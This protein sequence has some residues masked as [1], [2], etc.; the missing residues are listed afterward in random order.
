MS[1]EVEGGPKPPLEQDGF[2]LMKKDS[3]RRKT[4]SE[5]LSDDK[6]SICSVWMERIHN[7]LTDATPLLDE[8]CIHFLFCLLIRYI[9]TLQLRDL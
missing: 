7:E 2:Y 4:L 5:V 3:Q 1:P 6:D 9:F 8:V